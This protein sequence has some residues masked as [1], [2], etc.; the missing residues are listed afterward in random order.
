MIVVDASVLAP[1]LADDGPDG[2]RARDRLRGEVLT[3]PEIIDLEVASVLRRTAN[4]GRL[5]ERRADLALNDL[6]D[7]PLRRA[8]H[9]PLLHRCWELRHTITSY[10]AAYVALAEVLGV[11]LVTADARL[12]RAPGLTCEVEVLR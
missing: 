2:D 9:R 5:P 11:V 3:A 4:G 12:S 6:V 1:A 10:D 8:G 7:L